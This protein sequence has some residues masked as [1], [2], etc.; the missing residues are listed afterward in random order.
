MER[1]RVITTRHYFSTEIARVAELK[2]CCA[3]PSGHT[4]GIQTTS[5]RLNV[6]VSRPTPIYPILVCMFQREGGHA[7]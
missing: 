6:R 3:P 2:F 5:R 7:F 4:F 1:T